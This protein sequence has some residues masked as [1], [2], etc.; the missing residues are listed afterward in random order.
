VCVEEKDNFGSLLTSVNLPELPGPYDFCFHNPYKHKFIFT[1]LC[2]SNDME[3]I[4][5]KSLDS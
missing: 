3:R 4:W 5:N 1:Q 2:L